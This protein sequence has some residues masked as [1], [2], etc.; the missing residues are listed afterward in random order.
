M[1]SALHWR[2]AS[3]LLKCTSIV[4]AI[5]EGARLMG[6]A[7]LLFGATNADDI[8][9]A[10]QRAID[11]LCGIGSTQWIFACDGEVKERAKNRALLNQ[12]A[13]GRA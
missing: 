7:P 1:F 13:E 6:N 4:V 12:C 8:E 11:T 2:E 3:E 9:A 5:A 10:V